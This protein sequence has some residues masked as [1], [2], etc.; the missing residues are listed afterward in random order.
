MPSRDNAPPSQN[1]QLGPTAPPQSGLIFPFMARCYA[2][3]GRYSWLL[4]R[5]V[6][7]VNLIPHGAKKLFGGIEGTA[8]F[9]AG[10]G[11]EPALF[12]T[13]L[14]AVTEF[15]GGILLILGLFT[16]PAAAAVAVFM[17]VAVQ[18]HYANGFFWGGGG[19]EYPLMWGVMALAIF[20][21]GA[22]A[23]SLDARIGHEF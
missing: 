2:M 15:F 21:R 4:I 10:A 5:V 22:G 7:G 20:L 9:F 19:Y 8:A 16:R 17:A 18:H 13:W 3:G 14:V 11:Y 6:T 23:C 1:P 12:L